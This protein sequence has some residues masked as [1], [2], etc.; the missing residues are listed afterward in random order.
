M[1]KIGLDS[2]GYPGVSSGLVAVLIHL[3]LC[4]RAPVHFAALGYAGE[5][6]L[7]YRNNIGGST[8]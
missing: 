6:E 4:L 3:S 2:T 7:Y 5:P 1:V 8:G